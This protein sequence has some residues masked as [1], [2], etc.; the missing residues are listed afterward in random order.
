M[1]NVC[2]ALLRAVVLT[3]FGPPLAPP[4]RKE[5]A[6]PG[7]SGGKDAE[8]HPDMG[9]ASH[10]GKMRVTCAPHG[11]GWSPKRSG[12]AR[13]IGIRAAA[14]TRRQERERS[15]KTRP[16]LAASLRGAGRQR[17]KNAQPDNER[18]PKKERSEGSEADCLQVMV[19]RMPCAPSLQSPASAS[20]GFRES[21]WGNAK[22]RTGEWREW[23]MTHGAAFTKRLR[24]LSARRETSEGTMLHGPLGRAA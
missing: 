6:G 9:H 11:F 20:A 12:S 1:T 3:Q 8:S 10:E 18:C 16:P 19:V 2:N 7:G 15:V 21:E 24:E 5:G 4:R 13:A 22:T 23:S 14:L 17:R